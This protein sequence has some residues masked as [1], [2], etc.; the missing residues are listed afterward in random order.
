VNV[1][2][3]NLKSYSIEELEAAQKALSQELRRRNQE[4]KEKEILN[5]LAEKYGLT[6]IRK[7]EEE[8]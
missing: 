3:D 2:L 7:S 1:D 6:V 8:K 4:K 5:R